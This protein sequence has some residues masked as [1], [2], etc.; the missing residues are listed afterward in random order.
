MYL[1]SILFVHEECLPGM[2]Q[3][4]VIYCDSMDDEI[5]KMKE[6]FH[7]CEILS[8]QLERVERGPDDGQRAE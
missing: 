5:K 7:G 3:R 6:R 4:I 1:A 8:A 2:I